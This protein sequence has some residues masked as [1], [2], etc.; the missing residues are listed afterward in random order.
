MRKRRGLQEKHVRTVVKYSKDCSDLLFSKSTGFVIEKL[1]HLIL[2]GVSHNM[3]FVLDTR[4]Y[5]LVFL[6]FFKLILLIF[7][8]FS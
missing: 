8:I 5:F 4:K 2:E 6:I 7:N 3:Y 1:I